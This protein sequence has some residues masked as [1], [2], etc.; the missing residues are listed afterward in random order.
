[1]DLLAHESTRGA[2]SAAGQ[3]LKRHRWNFDMHVYPIEQRTAD[4]GNVA[5][6]LKWITFARPAS[7]SQIP[8]RT[9]VHGRHEDETSGERARTQG[10]GNGHAAFLQRLAQNFQTAAVKL[11]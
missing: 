11:R 2:I 9:W 8:A 3:F 5:L 10:A 1:V 4:A 7:I 6:D